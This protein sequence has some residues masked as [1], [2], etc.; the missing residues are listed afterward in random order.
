ML[1]FIFETFFAWY[2]H[3]NEIYT[4]EEPNCIEM[5]MGNSLLTAWS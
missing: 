4:T 5:K 3:R 1:V 2:F